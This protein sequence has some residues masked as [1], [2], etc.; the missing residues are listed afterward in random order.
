MSTPVQFDESLRL[1][2]DNK[3]VVGKALEIV[4]ERQERYGEVVIPERRVKCADCGKHFDFVIMPR[5][6]SSGIVAPVVDVLCKACGDR[7]WR[8]KGFR[9]PRLVCV[10]CKEVVMVFDVPKSGKLKDDHGFTWDINRFYHVQ[11]CPRC[12]KRAIRSSEIIEKIVF[13]KKHGIPYA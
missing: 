3:Q 4:L 5:F 10:G 1:S 6:R 2:L 9:Y 13:Y 12:A 7:E 8:T 11:E